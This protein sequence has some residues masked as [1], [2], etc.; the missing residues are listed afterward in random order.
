M[1]TLKDYPYWPAGGLDDAKE[2]LRI[3]CN[4]RKD[5]ITQVQ[6][7]SSQ[8]WQGR[9]VGKIPADSDDV[10][11]SDKIGDLSY[12]YNAGTPYL[13]LLMDDG[14]DGKWIRFSGSTF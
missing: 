12:D 7:L 4:L 9:S 14:A 11:A 1:T 6:S 5:D 13:Y 3:I 10:L 2:Q 8:F